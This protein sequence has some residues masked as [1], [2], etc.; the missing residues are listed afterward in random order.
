MEIPAPGGH[1]GLQKFGIYLL[2]GAAGMMIYESYISPKLDDKYENWSLGPLKG[3]FFLY[4]A[5]A[6]MGA[7]TVAK[8][9]PK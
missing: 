1:V 6:L 5:A 2:G 7:A 9:A 3:T 4:T 8:F